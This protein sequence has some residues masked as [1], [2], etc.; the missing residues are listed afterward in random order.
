MWERFCLKGRERQAP[1]HDLM[2]EAQWVEGRSRCEPSP[3]Q[4]AAK[5]GQVGSS[6]TYSWKVGNGY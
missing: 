6:L 4:F 3:V 5:Q 1:K 2:T